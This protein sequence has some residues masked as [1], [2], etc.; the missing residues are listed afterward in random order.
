MATGSLSQHDLTATTEAVEIADI[1]QSNC[2]RWKLLD[3]LTLISKSL[4]VSLLLLGSAFLVDHWAYLLVDGGS[5]GSSGRWLYFLLLV[6]LLPVVSLYSLLRSLKGRINPLFVAQQ[7]ETLSPEIKNSVSNYWQVK[8][9]DHVHP[10]IAR[11]MAQR[12]HNDLD[13]ERVHDG[14]DSTTTSWWGYS[15]LSCMA[16]TAIYFAF[17]PTPSLQTLHRILLPWDSVQRPSEITIQDVQPGDLEVSYGATLTVSAKIE[18]I[19]EDTPVHLIREALDGSTGQSKVSMQLINGRYQALIDDAPRGLQQSFQYWIEAGSPET[20]TALSNQYQVTVKPS[21]SIRVTQLDITYPEYTDLPN[22]THTRQFNLQAL[23]GSRIRIHT[24]ANADIDSAWIQLRTHHGGTERRP[25]Q[26][27]GARTAELEFELIVDENQQSLFSGYQAFFKN[28]AG[29]TNPQAIEYSIDTLPDLVPVIEF[30]KPTVRE[31]RQGPIE[32]A[33]NQTIVLEWEAYDPDFVLSS[34]TM[35]VASQNQNDIQIPLYDVTKTNQVPRLHSTR[36]T[37]AQYNLPAGSRITVFAEAADNRHTTSNPEP[38]RSQSEPLI[39]HITEPAESSNDSSGDESSNNQDM[40]NEMSDMM[41][42]KPSE[43]SGDDGMSPEGGG[44]NSEDSMGGGTSENAEE[45]GEEGMENGGSGSEGN[46]SDEPKDAMGDNSPSNSGGN[47]SD[48]QEGTNNDGMPGDEGAQDSPGTDTGN[49]PGDDKGMNT[50]DNGQVGEESSG[51]GTD[52]GKEPQ[53]SDETVSGDPTG[54]SGNQ[55]NADNVPKREGGSKSDDKHDGDIFEKLLDHLRDQEG[56]RSDNADASPMPN[57]QESDSGNQGEQ[58]SDG[59]PPPGQ[60]NS[61]NPTGT[62]KQPGQQTDSGQPKTG[63]P[64]DPQNN[65]MPVDP[66]AEGMNTKD[67]G[68]DP[69]DGNNGGGGEQTEAEATTGTQ[70]GENG[71]DQQSD[72]TAESAAEPNG[73]QAT[74]TPGSGDPA[75]TSGGTTD[76]TGSEANTQSG[77]GQQNTNSVDDLGLPEQIEASEEAQLDY[78]RKAT[79]L[80]LKYLRDHQDN[81]SDELLDD[82]GITADQLREMVARY[83][84][85][86]Q[87]TSASGQETLS[88]TLKSLGL[89]PSPKTSVRQVEGNRKDVQGVTGSGV[90]SGLP[91]DLQQRF[92]SF[93]TGTTVSDE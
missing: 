31:V 77:T 91:A 38:N 41:E 34:V 75:E 62:E 57:P 45:G 66:N 5:L 25:M 1:L 51:E 90:L 54:E 72:N 15:S 16:V 10:S 26:K 23:A 37:P 29:E 8:S 78:A 21:P 70:A 73:Q 6:I 89:R 50:S 9:A 58:T 27:T 30:T 76:A 12:A 81:P 65:N 32:L 7:I 67:P 59:N 4:L 35:N 18:G 71:S 64:A 84:S 52:G 93:R 85:L 46:P 83:E 69:R 13:D 2:R 60:E 24:L 86:K 82:L 28:T 55:E 92:K 42:D 53:S 49:D 33:A 11:S 56:K 20:R 3:L 14:V 39:I 44:N 19:D 40:M 87:D 43:E 74:D 36:F 63:E 47:P 80:A 22:V 48:S 17:M 88:D 79:D 61:Q 68:K